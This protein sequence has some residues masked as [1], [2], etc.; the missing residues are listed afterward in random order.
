[1]KKLIVLV[2][3][4]V[5]LFSFTGCTRFLTD[6]QML[7]VPEEKNPVVTF[8]IE[9]EENN[10][11][12]WV[13]TIECVLYYSKAP[14]TVAHFVNLVND[15]YYDSKVFHGLYNVG[16]NTSYYM[17]AG[18]YELSEDGTKFVKDTEIDYNIRGEFPANEWEKNDLEHKLGS[19][20]MDRSIGEDK[21]FD[22]ASTNFYFALNDFGGRTN[23]YAVFGQIEKMKLECYINDAVTKYP[24]SGELQNGIYPLFLNKM[25]TMDRANRTTDQQDSNDNDIILL[26]PA[27]DI[28]IVSAKVDTK[29]IDYS[30]AKILK[31][32]VKNK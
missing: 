15:G 6:K 32:K 9:Y 29:E 20:V 24:E 26:S 23:N 4:M 3:A 22:T 14:S 31:V 30:K 16:E 28:K 27:S 5:C 2:L 25:L 7:D 1:M 10:S 21:L 13:A 11:T 19:L 18:T 8:V 17:V 12:R